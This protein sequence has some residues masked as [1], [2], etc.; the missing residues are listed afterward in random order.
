MSE[1]PVL[2]YLRQATARSDNDPFNRPGVIPRAVLRTA[3]RKMA[4]LLAISIVLTLLSAILNSPHEDFQLRSTPAARTRSDS[5]NSIKAS[6]IPI[7]AQCICALKLAY[8]RP[9]SI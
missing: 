8:F 1:K 5:S 3:E 6:E 7:A 2:G 9:I 4:I